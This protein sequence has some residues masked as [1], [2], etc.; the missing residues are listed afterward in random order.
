MA[1]KRWPSG[2]IVLAGAVALGVALVMGRPSPSRASTWIDE[3]H[4]AVA[5]L[6]PDGIEL[7]TGCRYEAT[8][9]TGGAPVPG[10]TITVA[11]TGATARTDASGRYSIALPGAG[12]WTLTA[13]AP[14]FAPLSV[15][16]VIGDGCT[17]T[18][19]TPMGGQATPAPT[20]PPSPTPTTVVRPRAAGVD[21]FTGLASIEGRSAP[22]GTVVRALIADTVCGTARTDAT[23]RYTL[24]IPPATMVRGCGTAGVAIQFTVTPPFGTGWQLGDAAA[25]QPD[26]TMTHDLAVDLRRL[27]PDSANVPWNGT[28]W[29]DAAAIPVGICSSV[30]AESESAL[31]AAVA[32]WNRASSEG[33]LRYALATDDA[34]ACAADGL[35]IAVVEDRLSDPN[36]LAGT[37]SVDA[38]YKSCSAE[39][40]CY[41]LKSLILINGPSFRRLPV[42]DRENVIAHEIGH[43]LGLGHADRCNGGTI[44]WADTRCRFPLNNVGVDDIAA[45]NDKAAAVA[46]QIAARPDGAGMAYRLAVPP[47]E[48]AELTDEPGTL[49][50]RLLGSSLDGVEWEYS[51]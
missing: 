29:S 44:M 3:Q 38:D 6:S 40:P 32:Q 42:L 12:T 48:A 14:G 28:F 35:G 5:P 43:A 26:A 34:A 20:A 11:E 24:D 7:Q 23:G 15:Q 49:V 1:M 18:S 4:A 47:A 8:I 19:R 33:G 51:P 17:L 9:T 41:A 22:A 13:T 10:A 16:L 30:S 21:R 36:A 27:P 2:W 31:Q 50:E 39:Q 46:T 45:L 25:F 37:K